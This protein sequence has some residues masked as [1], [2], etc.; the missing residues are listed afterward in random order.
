MKDVLN[1]KLFV[2]VSLF[3]FSF[4]PSMYGM[5]KNGEK[6]LESGCLRGLVEG[7][8]LKDGPFIIVLSF[9]NY[10]EFLGISLVCRPFC[11]VVRFCQGISGKN[12]EKIMGLREGY[13]DKISFISF[14]RLARRERHLFEVYFFKEK[15]REFLKQCEDFENLDD[16]KKSKFLVL[17][18]SFQ[19]K[20]E[21]LDRCTGQNV[22]SL[23]DENMPKRSTVREFREGVSCICKELKLKFKNFDEESVK[24]LIFYWFLPVLSRFSFHIDQIKKRELRVVKE[25][26][27]S[28]LKDSDL[29]FGCVRSFNKPSCSGFEIFSKFEWAE[30][31]FLLKYLVSEF[32][33]NFSPRVESEIKEKFQWI[34][35]SGAQKRGCFDIIFLAIKSL[36]SR[37]PWVDILFVWLE[38]LFVEGIL[39]NEYEIEIFNQFFA[40]ARE[41]KDDEI[42]ICY[43]NKIVK[44]L[45]KSLDRIEDL[46]ILL[47][48]SAVKY[49]LSYK[50]LDGAYNDR[51]RELDE[52]IGGG[53]EYDDFD[54][55][56]F[57]DLDFEVG[58]IADEIREVIEYLRK[59]RDKYCE[60]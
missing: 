21:I 39:G 41:I 45:I 19:I 54:V 51:H 49:H 56:E 47:E 34:I 23:V 60:K 10:N 13:G 29:D 28:I 11:R 27:D 12:F 52:F 4:V 31:F 44:N 46:K 36:S 22:C 32:N 43:V 8:N 48:E 2:F 30:E 18:I 38:A 26:I 1:K 55:P 57:R 50:L 20:A 5:E 33:K 35:L 59:L 15:K 42:L 40:Q 9:L 37:F 58:L 16:D 7:Q 6:G 17:A 24:E 14:L 53:N 25:H 3:C